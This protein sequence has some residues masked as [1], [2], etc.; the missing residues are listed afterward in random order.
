M[1]WLTK[2]APSTSNTLIDSNV[3]QDHATSG[4][5]PETGKVTSKRTREETSPNTKKARG[6]LWDDDDEFIN[7]LRGLV[8]QVSH[9]SEKMIT[10]EDI[11]ADLNALHEEVKTIKTSMEVQALE[12]G[13]M[14]SEFTALAREMD[15]KEKR[16]T[17]EIGILKS[18]L[19]QE[20]DHT[21]ILMEKIDDLE[22]RSR[23]NNVV[24]HG[25]D[26][27]DN[28]TWADAEAKVQDFFRNQL[29]VEFQGSIQRAHRLGKRRHDR[30][31]RPIIVCCSE[32]KDKDKVMLSSS[33]LKGSLSYISEDF[34]RQVR[35]ARRNL[36]KYAKERRWSNWKV[37]FDKLLYDGN[38]FRYDPSTAAVV[39]VHQRQQ[40]YGQNVQQMQINV[41]SESQI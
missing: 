17:E 3:N 13:Q 26:E 28:E 5:S 40:P 24:I 30:R 14:K 12:I 37:R 36:I 15:E 35:D 33:R 7:L 32:W 19:K 8:Q 20:R 41:D 4:I 6:E 1:S 10:K 29:Q 23:R 2:S 34:S 27:C 18:K 22:N 11:K 16:L 25:I 39:V 21:S 9:M 31:P 38:V